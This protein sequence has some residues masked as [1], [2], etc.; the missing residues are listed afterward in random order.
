[1]HTRGNS[2]LFKGK[3][4]GIGYPEDTETQSISKSM[5]PIP[6]IGAMTSPGA[7]V[8]VAGYT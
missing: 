7:L 4:W 8:N 3:S 2:I 5:Q 6:F 1:M